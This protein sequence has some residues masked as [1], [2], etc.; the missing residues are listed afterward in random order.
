[1]PG[2]STMKPFSC[3]SQSIVIIWAHIRLCKLA[4]SLVPVTCKFQVTW[5]L[6]S[7]ISDLS[8]LTVK[9]TFIWGNCDWNPAQDAVVSAV[10]ELMVPLSQ[11]VAQTPLDSL[12]PARSLLRLCMG[13]AADATLSRRCHMQANV[14]E[15]RLVFPNAHCISGHR[16]H[17]T[18]FSQNILTIIR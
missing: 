9:N 7:Y 10:S 14:H 16:R 4:K 18:M 17:L 12:T 11:S 2:D 15:G 5:N 1:M 13:R 8:V 3:S 6:E